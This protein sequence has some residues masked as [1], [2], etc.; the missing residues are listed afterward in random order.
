MKNGRIAALS[1]ALAA[2]GPVFSG[3]ARAETLE[4]GNASLIQ[5][6]ATSDNRVYLRNL[7]TFNAS[8]LGCC[9]SY[10]ID[11]TR[12]AGQ[13]QFSALLSAAAL[14]GPISIY[15]ASASVGGEVLQ[16]GQF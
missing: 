1:I 4:V 8:W 10:Y 11:L 16:V 14:K 3:S 12:P 6:A 5:Y 9:G 2:F 13:A 7:S 15:V